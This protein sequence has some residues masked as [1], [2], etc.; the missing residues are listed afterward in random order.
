MDRW[1][2]VECLARRSREKCE[3]RF[4]VWSNELLI[5]CFGVGVESSGF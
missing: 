2:C 3:W 4:R 5:V 1:D